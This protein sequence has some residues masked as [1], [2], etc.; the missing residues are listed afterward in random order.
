MMTISGLLL[1]PNGESIGYMF[2]DTHGVVYN[3][4]ITANS[5][6]KAPKLTQVKKNLR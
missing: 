1:V 5:T 3:A 2:G 4:S 6:Q